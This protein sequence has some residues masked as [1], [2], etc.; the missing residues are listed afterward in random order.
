M[1]KFLLSIFAVMLAVL[2]VQAQSYVKVTSA[3]ADWSG[4]YL[5]VYEAGNVAFNGG[6]TTLDATSNTVAVTISNG[7]IAATDA[8]NKAKFTIAKSGTTY[9][10]KSASGYYIGNNSNSNTL[11]SSTGTSYSNTITLNNDGTAHIVGKGTSVLRYNASSGQYRFR[12][13]KSS[14][15]ASQ[16]A[17]ALYKYVDAEGGETQEP[18]VGLP[19]V[20]VDDKSTIDLGDEIIISPAVDNTVTYSVNNGA[21]IQ[22]TETTTITADKAGV[23]TLSIASTC[24]DETLTAEY[25]YYVKPA[26]PTMTDAVGFE[27][28]LDVEIEGEGEIY[29]TLNGDDPTTE[30]DIYDGA[31]TITKTTTVKAIAVSNG[32]ASDV[33][34]E[35]Y[36]KN[37]SLPDGW[38]VD[39]LNRALT[40]IT[41]TSYSNWSGK[42]VTSD[43][44]Y[45]GQSAGGND[46]IQLRSSNSNSGII[47]TK[48]GGKVKKV[49]VEWQ[50]STS[51]GRT[52]N[53]YGKNSAYTAATDLYNSSNQGTLLGTIVKGTSTV[54]EIN[55]DYEYIGLRSNDGAMYLTSV[56]ITWDASAGVTV[57]PDAPALPASANF[58]N[59]F[60]VAITAEDGAAI[61]YTTDGTEPTTA[62]TVYS[63]PFTI[64][65]TTTIKAIAVKDDVVSTVAEATYTKVRLIDLSNCTVAEAIEAYKNGQT[66]TATITAYIVGAANGGLSKAEFTSETGV[67]TNI[68]IADNADETNVDNCMPIKMASG[69]AVR[70]ALNLGENKYVYKKKVVIV[71]E[72][73]AYFSVAGMQ[74]VEKAGL[75]WTVSNAGYATLY[76]GYKAEIPS[77]VNAYIVE[78]TNSTHAIMTKVE[79]IVAANTGLILEGEGEHLFN[80]TSSAVTADVEN[81]LLEGTV[82]ATEIDVEAYVL[83]YVDGVGLYKAEMTDGKWLNNANKAYLPAS[84]VPNKTVAFYGFDWDGTTGVEEVKTENGEVKTIYDLTGRRVEEITA[85]G[86]YIVNGVKRVVR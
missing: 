1:K 46:A 67:L 37:E 32:V 11:T 81:N 66:G 26:M 58:E 4:D 12:Y 84:A 50:S 40:G 75:Y 55:G 44:V 8:I 53:V 6:L 10:I 83:G 63:A 80:I 79:G 19:A 18:E 51:N 17:I 27:E 85:P 49:V 38:F 20:S 72:L 65:E 59:E 28:S 14:S 21:S 25:T 52:L 30:S 22:I 61:Y 23:M 86:I 77:T 62:S 34:S 35:I 39:V 73:E 69:T 45:A 48:S 9:T 36:T 57:V 29:Y 68:L 13:Y 2:G 3:P 54:L 41:T 7:E 64:S 33:A 15:Y 60:E 42:T 31:I 47:T 78:S 24:N 71:G 56:S 43:A 16:K 76:L 70:N 82:A 74:D 5:I